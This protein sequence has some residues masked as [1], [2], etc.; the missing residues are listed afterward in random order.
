[1]RLPTCK[2]CEKARA[3]LSACREHEGQ[4]EAKVERLREA[5]A[6]VVAHAVHSADDQVTCTACLSPGD[7]ACPVMRHRALLSKEDTE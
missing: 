5:L 2:E 4:L 1:M 3:E 6:E 7:D